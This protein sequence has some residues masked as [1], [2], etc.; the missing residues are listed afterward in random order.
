[1]QVRRLI[2]EI[3]VADVARS[4]AF[5]R[6]HLG[7]DV[8]HEEAAFAMLER[9]EQRIDVSQRD[10]HGMKL[11]LV[12]SDIAALHSRVSAVDGL[13]VSPLEPRHYWVWEFELLD[14][15]GTILMCVQPPPAPGLDIPE[16][17]EAIVEGDDDGVADLLAADP[18][19]GLATRGFNWG[20]GKHDNWSTIQIVAGAGSPYILA[21]ALE[22]GAEVGATEASAEHWTPLHLA[23]LRNPDLVEPLLATGKVPVDA[24]CAAAMGWLDQLAELPLNAGSGGATPL[25]FAAG[26]GQVEAV[27][28]CLSQGIAATVRDPFYDMTPSE[29]AAWAGD[30]AEEI[31][32]LL[33]A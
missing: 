16:L 25:H 23:A 19:G 31:R 10:G 12:V 7:F 6:D 22:A 30:S 8:M 32:A 3:P 27:R 5:Y 29:W 15:D 33:K 21:L 17:F 13:H 4:V 28:H 2:P 24:C 14:P 20:W 1:M 18:M 11:W 9:D 26:R